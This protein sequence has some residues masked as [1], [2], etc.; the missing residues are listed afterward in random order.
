MNSWPWP[1]PEDDGGAR[2]LIAGTQLPDVA[3]EST[4]GS[5]VDLARREGAAVLFVYP[6]TGTPGTPN[7]PRWDEIPGAH[8]STPEAEGFRDHHQV[9]QDLG[10]GVFG[11]SGQTSTDQRAF[12]ARVGLTFPVLSDTGFA[13]AA[14][15]RLPRFETGGVKY[16]RRI[17]FIIRDG[18][19]EQ[20]IYPVHPPDRHAQDLVSRLRS[21]SAR[22]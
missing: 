13:F 1:A 9:L 10:L 22:I 17:S 14:A 18:V 5:A 3:L 2:H 21:T 20:T 11:L 12:A 4:T 8:G 7:P 16:L 19:I 6:F 15:L